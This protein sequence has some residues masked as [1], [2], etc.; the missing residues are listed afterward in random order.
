[1]FEWVEDILVHSCCFGFIRKC[2][3]DGT[4]A[5]CGSREGEV[6]SDCGLWVKFS[7][8]GQ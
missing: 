4:E 1:M 5:S 6:N 7:V 2:L 3:L 8:K